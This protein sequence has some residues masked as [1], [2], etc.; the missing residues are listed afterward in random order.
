MSL[1]VYVC[2]RVYLC[3]EPRGPASRCGR[4]RQV[5]SAATS[6]AAVAP[7]AA[8]AAATLASESD[9]SARPSTASQ[10]AQ[11]D[12]VR[13]AR[14]C[15]CSSPRRR[16]TLAAVCS[17][18]E[19]SSVSVG[20]QS[21]SVF[22]PLESTASHVPTRTGRDGNGHTHSRQLPATPAAI[23]AAAARQEM[24]N[25]PVTNC[26]FFPPTCATESGGSAFQRTRKKDSLHVAFCFFVP[27]GLLLWS[28]L[29]PRRVGCAPPVA[30][31]CSLKSVFERI[32]A[33]VRTYVRHACFRT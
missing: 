20:A 27:R 6:A 25:R 9:R 21:P 1:D 11:M 18:E 2:P 30:C 10:R 13:R 26:L 19:R 33:A 23:W 29:F 14:T 5:P 24:A 32:T 4:C 31:C 8:A 28:L 16:A 17:E 12:R 3:R 15:G 22:I 7:S